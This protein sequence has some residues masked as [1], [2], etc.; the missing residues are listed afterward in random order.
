MILSML[1]NRVVVKRNCDITDF[2]CCN[3]LCVGAGSAGCYAAD[4]AAREGAKVIL[5]EI[6]E[7]IGGMHVCG[8]VTGYYYG[9]RGGSYEEDDRKSEADTVFLTSK[10]HWEQR[11]IRLTERLLESGVKVLCRH[12]VIGL[13]FEDNRIVGVLAFNGEREVTIKADITIDAT[14]DGH[15]IRMTDIKKQYGRPSDGSFIPFGVFLRYTKNGKLCAKNNDS[16]IMD[17]YAG[18]D[19]SQKTIMAHANLSHLLEEEAEVVGC[20]LQTGIREGLIYEG[21]DTL[22]YEDILFGKQSEKVLFWAYS[23]LDRH[24]SLRAIDDEIVQNWWVISNLSTAVI[25]I[26]VSMGSIVPKNIKGLVTAG[27]CLSF[28]TYI[29]S[30][31]RMNTDMFR[32]GECVGIAAAMA[33]LAGV[34][35]LEINYEKYLARAKEKGCFGKYCRITYA[36]DNSYKMYLD[37][38]NALGRAPDKKYEGLAP[39][40]SIYEPIC[41]DADKNFHLL[42]TDAPGVAIWS[43]YVSTKKEAIKERLYHEILHADGKLYKFNCAVALGLL[44]DTRALP[45]LREIVQN[46]DCFFFIDNRRSNQFRS[47]IAVCLLGRLGGADDSAML[48][49]ILS[50]KEIDRTMYHTLEA[51]YLYHNYPDRNFVYFSVL[52]HTCMAIYKIYKRCKLDMKQLHHFFCDFFDNDTVLHNITEG[53]ANTSAEEEMKGFIAYLLNLTATTLS[54]F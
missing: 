20:A 11:Q 31:V 16:G 39:N 43:C 13:Y 30:A 32:M 50:S 41:F 8:N 18:K 12:S 25:S 36:F 28:D 51:N 29:Q 26:P 38:M 46:R 45:I 6:G 4:S 49:D 1:E 9:A 21:E 54:P 37:K 27:R 35:F 34:D 2:D 42:K 44:E 5:L 33:T 48:F 40:A 3:V 17:H 19:F 7:N 53:R 23:D 52:T 47:A 24:G 22:R 14:S 15:L 10:R